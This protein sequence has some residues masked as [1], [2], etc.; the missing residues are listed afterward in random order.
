V[1]GN[2]SGFYYADLSGD[3]M[4]ELLMF[5][6]AGGGALEVWRRQVSRSKA[7]AREEESIPCA[8]LGMWLFMSST[9]SVGY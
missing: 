2:G 9:F 8:S 7:S 1:A 5:R 6:D 3:C 4:P